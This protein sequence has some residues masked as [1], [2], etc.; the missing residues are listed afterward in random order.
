M[1]PFLTIILLL[2]TTVAGFT[3]T[4]TVY[5]QFAPSGRK[6]LSLSVQCDKFGAYAKLTRQDIGI[7]KATEQHETVFGIQYR[8]ADRVVMLAGTGINRLKTGKEIKKC[9]IF[10]IGWSYKVI[11]INR[12][13]FDI[14]AG[15][16]TSCG[17]WSG[18]GCGVKI[19]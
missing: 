19:N 18:I 7:E 16:S 6:P 8:I 14:Q 13:T 3:Q 11:E 2:V 1:K 15:L 5:R 10:E 12:F 9:A 17:V 4:Y